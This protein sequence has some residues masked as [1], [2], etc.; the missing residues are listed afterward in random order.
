VVDIRRGFDLLRRLPYVDADRIVYVGHSSGA[1]WGAIL[2]AVDK[3]MKATVLIGGTPDQ[4]CIYLESGEPEFVALR[5]REAVGEIV[6][7]LEAVGQTDAIHFIGHAAPVPLLF[8]FARFER[9]FNEPAMQRY[10]NAA[11]EPKDAV[12]YNTGHE[13]NDP[14][15]LIDRSEWLARTAGLPRLAPLLV[16]QLKRHCR[17]RAGGGAGAWPAAAARAA[18][19]R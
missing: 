14:Q 7:Y 5:E 1:Q 3:R 15:V 9:Y 10:F 17:L 13:L 16:R 8:Q 2:S 6:K 18:I 19:R 11:S 4:A 12:W